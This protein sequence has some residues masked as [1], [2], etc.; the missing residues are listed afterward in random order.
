MLSAIASVNITVGAEAEGAVSLIPNQPIMPI[1]V[2]TEKI[3]TSS[4]AT[5]PV[6][7]RNEKNVISAITRYMSGTSVLRSFSEDSWKALLKGAT[8]VK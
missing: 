2:I 6:T 5:V 7:E 8:P 1:A 4:V 3:T